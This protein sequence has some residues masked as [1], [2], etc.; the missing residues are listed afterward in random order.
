MEYRGGAYED[1]VRGAFCDHRRDGFPGHD[2]AD[3]ASHLNAP[4]LFAPIDADLP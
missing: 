4:A 2:A 1:T 3:V